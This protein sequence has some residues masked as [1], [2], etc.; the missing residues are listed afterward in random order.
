MEV[1]LWIII[2]SIVIISI[3]AFILIIVLVIDKKSGLNGSCRND[4]NCESPYVCTVEG[5][6]PNG[7]CK[8]PP[9]NTCQATTDCVP[10]FICDPDTKR[11][12]P[13]PTLNDP[14]VPQ[15]G[16]GTGYTCVVEGTGGICKS[17]LGS[18]CQIDTDCISSLICNPTTKVCV[19]RPTVT[20]VESPIKEEVVK[21]VVKEVIKE[22]SPINVRKPTPQ[23]VINTIKKSVKLEVQ[24]VDDEI[25]SNGDN[26]DGPFDVRSGESTADCSI[27]SV[28]TPCQEKE[29]VYYCRNTQ[30]TNVT[31]PHSSVIDVCSYSNATVFLL[32]D[33]NIICEIVDTK[34]RYRAANNIILRRIVSF[35]GYL[36]GIG[37]DNILYTL[38]NKSFPTTNWFWTRVNW[39]PD[40]IKHIST[41]HSS[42]HLWIQTY[43]KG[44]LYHSSAKV[45]FETEY[46]NGKRVYGRD[47]DHYIDIDSVKFT[48]AIYPNKMLVN[49]IYDA[50]L[51]YYDEIIAIHPN[52]R[53]Q[54]NGITIVNWQPYYIRK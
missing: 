34:R 12:E 27:S 36:Y 31:D 52:E 48:G 43:T 35:D 21:E 15:I 17:S 47:V 23:Y 45:A 49:N 41:T 39:A 37:K 29:G 1:V 30:A 8:S 38:P 50:A 6:G 5:T 42:S 9:G 24:S 20:F 22:P 25:N 32:A 11:C 7:T 28:S 54:Y 19:A 46:I 3:I 53:D 4:S 10:N 13:K 40:M 26:I 14:C 51:S 16:C 33:G 2:I 44:Y 18:R